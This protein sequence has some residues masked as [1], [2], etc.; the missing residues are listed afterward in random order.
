MQK[1]YLLKSSM[2]NPV[3]NG[4]FRIAEIVG[5]WEVLERVFKVEL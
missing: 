5:L 1:A 3:R 4:L 2:T